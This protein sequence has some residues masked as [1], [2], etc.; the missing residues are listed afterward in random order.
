M[1]F[2]PAN[3]PGRQNRSE[4]IFPVRNNSDLVFNCRQ[5]EGKK[6]LFGPTCYFAEGFFSHGK[7]VYDY[8][9]LEKAARRGRRLMI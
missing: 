8:P 3:W 5:F 6:R 4:L 1:G 9:G 7:K 2:L